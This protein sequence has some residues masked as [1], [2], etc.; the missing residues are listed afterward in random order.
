MLE[1]RARPFR[2]W[3]ARRPLTTKLAQLRAYT[4]AFCTA[5]ITLLCSGAYAQ[6][7]WA[8]SYRAGASVLKAEVFTWGE[9]CG[10]R[11]QSATDSAKPKVEVK[12]RGN[13]LTLTFP[14]RS[15]RSDGC[16][17]PNPAVR[18]SQASA[19]EGSWRV[20]C[21]TPA[22]DAKQERGIYTLSARVQDGHALLE[23]V[24]ESSYDWQLKQSHCVAK[25]RITQQMSR[26]GVIADPTPL[27]VAPAEPPVNTACTPGPLARLRIRPSDSRIA[28]GARQC[29]TVR[30]VDAAGCAVA[31]DNA[32][33]K[34]DFKKPSGSSGAFSG[35]CFKAAESAAEAEGRFV[36]SV[37]S[38]SVRDEAKLT[39]ATPDL[40]DIIA[41]RG[42]GSSELDVSE[43]SEGLSSALGIEAVVKGSSLLVKLAISA[44]L[45]G[46]IGALAWLIV[47]AR[48]GKKK[49]R[50]RRY[51]LDEDEDSDDGSPPPRHSTINS[52]APRSGPDPSLQGG[53]GDQLICPTCRRGVPLGVERCPNDGTVPVPYAE[54]VKAAREAQARPRTCPSCGAQLAAGALF[55]GT[56]GA[57]VRP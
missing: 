21:K 9:D 45:L 22:G 42:S 19:S 27:P 8:G 15:V 43:D 17:S 51:N 40:S 55:C 10:P 18:V 48:P 39:V 56:C 12:A 3:Y 52:L 5:C 50:R 4:V 29:F 14:D 30:G 25:V 28:P 7:D 44:L 38:G 46:L 33:L 49:P 37:A 13:Q 24:E 11:P 23:L 16:W 54:F 41:R 32:A 34:W 35:A 6:T 2:V 36:I 57:K 1:L 53:S 47:R 20:E 26:G 31:L